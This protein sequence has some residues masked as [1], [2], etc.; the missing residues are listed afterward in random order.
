MS[1]ELRSAAELPDQRGIKSFRDWRFY[2]AALLLAGSIFCLIR[3][4]Y[5]ITEGEFAYKQGMIVLLM[6]L[7]I[8]AAF[9][10]ETPIFGKP[11]GANLL[12]QS[13]SIVPFSLLMARLCAADGKSSQEIT[14]LKFPGFWDFVGSALTGLL[15]MIPAWIRDLFSNWHITLLFLLVLGILC[16]RRIQLRTGAIILI[17][18]LLFFRQFNREGTLVYLVAGTLL[19]TTALFFMF[20]RYDLVS[21]YENIIKRLKRS[22]TL[23]DE[24]VRTIL[25]VMEQLAR[26][27]RLSEGN[28]RQIVK[29]SY[30]VNHAYN[31]QELNMISNEMAKRMIYSYDLVSL[32]ND[33]EGIFLFPD[34][35]LYHD[36]NLLCSV[37]LVP[38]V[39]FVTL[40]SLLWIIMP[41]DLIPD[42]LP[43]V[44]VLDDM[45]VMI[46]SGIV[47]Q[48]S[49]LPMRKHHE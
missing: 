3:D 1:K 36:D 14:R 44:G 23:G 42:S 33:N 18:M 43:F 8:A 4:P 9:L 38:R 49:L 16:L 17:L 45:A 29:D 41:F 35:L 10:W 11:A 37:A 21:Y 24:E 46:L 7:T 5:F 34:P 30:T 25:R 6:A 19:L 12:L 28:F 48:G 20:S 26:K 32:R 15:E 27:K 22:N 2:L 39:M 31:D 40:F 13:F 47:I